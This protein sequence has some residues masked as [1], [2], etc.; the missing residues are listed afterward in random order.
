MTLAKCSVLGPF[1]QHIKAQYNNSPE[2]LYT[3]V[4]YTQHSESAPLK[5]RSG[6]RRRLFSE[7]KQVSNQWIFSLS[8]AAGPCEDSS[9]SRHFIS[10]GLEFTIQ[11]QEEDPQFSSPKY[12]FRLL[13]SLY[14]SN[15]LNILSV[16]RKRRKIPPP[17]P[18]LAFL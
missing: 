5:L 7:M 13:L 8:T 17:V 12:C 1:T 2:E 3:S 16:S 15:K 11:Q 10:L 4:L 14:F 18:P 6:R 9:H